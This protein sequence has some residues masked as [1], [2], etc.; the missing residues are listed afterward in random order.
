MRDISVPKSTIDENTRVKIYDPDTGYDGTASI[1]DI[2]LVRATT[3]P[4]G[5]VDLLGQEPIPELIGS[6]GKNSHFVFG[7]AAIHEHKLSLTR[8]GKGGVIGTAGKP[9]VSFRVDHGLDEFFQWFW[10]AMKARG[11]P[12]GLGVVAG[13]VGH[14]DD[15]Y[16]PTA[17]TWE[18]LRARMYEGVEIW[19]HSLTHRDPAVTG[20]SIYDEVVGAYNLFI[21]NG[22]VPQGSHRG[23]I[24]P[25]IEP[26]YSA[27][28]N[29][30]YSWSS[31]YGNLMYRTYGLLEITPDFGG[32]YRNLPTHG[33]A[34]LGHITLDGL[35]LN[36]AKGV[37]DT[38]IAYGYSSE[39][40]IHPVF[41]M[42]G[43]QV[44]NHADWGPLLD[45]VVEKRDAGDIEVLTPSGMHF[46]DP[47]VS[48]RLR[49][50]MDE[51]F[52]TGLPGSVG[53]RWITSA[54][55]SFGLEAGTDGSI[56]FVRL[57]PAAALKYIYQGNAFVKQLMLMGT[58]VEAYIKCRAPVS[59]GKM[60]VTIR[61]VAA[62]TVSMVQEIDLPL[63]SEWKWVRVPAT[64][65]ADATQVQL[66]IARV[67]T[68][69]FVLD[70]AEAH[71]RPV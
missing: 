44:F 34:N 20:N 13:T 3:G 64:L 4:G 31:S 51:K 40:M 46:A 41:I 47:N 22:I 36:Q 16:E 10:P 26:H 33:E 70:V 61:S 1:K 65:L 62:E 67:T 11:I 32:A 71:L 15:P 50:V 55:G 42:N 6:N 59:A 56:N 63:S 52:E 30:P 66:R 53:A 17:T 35:T 58:T 7:M 19:G 23:G 27:N 28:L 24:T 48:R 9:C 57:T 39:L 45:Y 18:T 60:G 25:T 54:N 2:G 38:C 68:G 29:M 5:G 69:S 21:E 43:N 8:R 12:A 49:I 14:P 37:I